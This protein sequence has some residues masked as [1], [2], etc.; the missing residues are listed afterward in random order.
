MIKDNTQ[1]NMNIVNEVFG[2]YDLKGEL[3]EI[4]PLGLGLINRTYEIIM[5]ENGTNKSY[6]LQKINT[7]IFPDVDGLMNNIVYVTSFLKEKI[8][9]RGG[10]PDRETLTVVD[11]KDGKHYVHASDDTFWRIYP[12]VEDTFVLNKVE[13]PEQF[14]E[15]GRSFGAFQAS[16][17]DFDATKLVEVI[18]KFHDTR[19]RLN[20]L[21][22]AIEKDEAG[23]VS[24]VRDEIDFALSRKDDCYMLYDMLDAG[25]LPLRVTHNDTKLNN[26][27]MDNT[28]KKGI[29]IVDLDTIMP[30]ISL[31]DF[32]DS[33]RYGANDC[34]EDEADLSKV[35]FDIKLFKT[36]AKGFIEGADGNLTQKE[37]ELLP[38]G[39]RVITLEQGIRFLTDYINGD[40][41]YGITRE[42]QNLDR[43]RVQFKLVSDME[44]IWDELLNAVK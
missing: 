30:G 13:T 2:K 3:V 25:E 1:D 14:F 18:P 5:N 4:K 27:L 16:L 11:S 23:R 10:D 35:N 34:A 15:T 36:Y 19:H 12:F 29:C 31:F 7:N 6:V 40:K 24:E 28:S 26:I 44:N 8:K 43:T 38:W 20:Q 41:Y 32:G 37:I 9:E 42:N 22:E 39:A 21:L 33:I 17:S